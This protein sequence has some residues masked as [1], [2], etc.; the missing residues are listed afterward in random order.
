MHRTLSLAPRSLLSAVAASTLAVALAWATPSRAEDLSPATVV[1]TVNGE[2]ITLGQM[3]IARSNLPEQYK[4]LPD[5]VLFSGI[6]DQLVQQTVLSQSFD[7]PEPAYIG[8][9]LQNQKRSLLASEVIDRLLAGAAT[10]ADVKAAYE[11]AYG[12]ADPAPEYNASHILVETEE[13]AQALIEELNSGADFAALAKEKSTG[14]SGPNGGALN[15]F[16]AGMMVKP[17]EDAVKELSEGD[18]S[19]PVQTQFGWHVIKLN[20]KRFADAPSLEEVRAELEDM[21]R[22]KVVEGRIQDLT[23]EADID[24]SAETQIDPSVLA[25][26]DFMEQ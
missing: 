5:E 18:I 8:I 19:G 7:G 25:R 15:W 13:A 21:I 2:D 4:Q 1:A 26:P 16:G 22:Q 9:V 3:A 24:R 20:Q 23:S 10:E 14:P 11:E 12:N 17:F 6:L